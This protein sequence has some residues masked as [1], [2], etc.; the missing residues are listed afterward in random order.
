MSEASEQL[1]VGGKQLAVSSKQQAGVE[2]LR[3]KEVEK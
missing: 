2:K 1:A 3:G